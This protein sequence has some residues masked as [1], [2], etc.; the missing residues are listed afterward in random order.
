MRKPKPKQA[1]GGA[2]L[3][4]S[5]KRVQTLGW[6]PDDWELIERAAERTRRPRTSFVQLAALDAARRVLAKG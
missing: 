1:S 3:V 6:L 4:A 2:R 5:G